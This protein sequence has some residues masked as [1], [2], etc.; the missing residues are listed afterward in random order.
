MCT[1]AP[2]S[3]A[4]ATPQG[5]NAETQA[6]DA[7]WIAALE[8]LKCT[9]PEAF[10]PDINGN[11]LITLYVTTCPVTVSQLPPLPTDLYYYDGASSYEQ[12]E[13][14]CNACFLTPAPAA[15]FRFAWFP[16]ADRPGGCKMGS[17][18]SIN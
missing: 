1:T 7:A 17:C 4:A 9:T 15:D 12:L 2:G 11:D 13:L 16:L 5:L 14:G 8:A 6:E 18:S 10:I 3:W